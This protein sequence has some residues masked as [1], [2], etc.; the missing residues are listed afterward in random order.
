MKYLKQF[1]NFSNE[2]ELKKL[3]SH[4]ISVIKEFEYQEK[5]YLDRGTW[6]TEFYKDSKYSF[7]I[8]MKIDIFTKKPYINLKITIPLK[9]LDPFVNA[10]GEYLKTI[11]DM[12]LIRE[13]ENLPW[14]I[15]ELEFKILDKDVNKIISQITKEDIEFKL[16]NNKFNI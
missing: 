11:K 10:F 7:R 13:R 5:N 14:K 8:K 6:E 15:S 3:L 4:L 16:L 2:T 12:T 1:E 9:F